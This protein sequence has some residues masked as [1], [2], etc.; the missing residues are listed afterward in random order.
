MILLN[1]LIIVLAI[2]ISYLLW[3]NTRYIEYFADPNNKELHIY[4]T[5]HLGDCI[6]T[7]INI[8]CNRDELVQKKR[9]VHFYVEPNHIKQLEEFIP[10]EYVKLHP[11][12]EKPESA[13]DTWLG[14]SLGNVQNNLGDDFMAFLSDHFNKLAPTTGL[15]KMEKFQYEDP[16]LLVRYAKLPYECK[17]CDILI[18]NSLPQSGQY[19][20]DD[21][22][23]NS[24]INDLHKRY[25]IITTRKV[26]GVPCTL[27][28]NLTVK[29]IATVSTGVKYIIGVNT[30]PLVGCFN[31]YTFNNV[32]K[33]YIFVNNCKFND[34]K[35]FPAMTN[36][37]FEI[38]RKELLD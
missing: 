16:D 20:L 19:R 2:A 38:I 35:Y 11:L 15:G 32:K 36:G 17:D 12:S 18:I 21:D 28:F 30:G 34:N 27:D 10:N 4:N 37:T 22:E 25:K 33:W 8:I 26:A 29:G 1:I 31:T 24:L 14:N 23:W 5:Y 13:V 7:L 6:F 9:Y 3:H